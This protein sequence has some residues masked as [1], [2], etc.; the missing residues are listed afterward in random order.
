MNTMTKKAIS[1]P[2]THTPT[3]MQK[4]FTKYGD[5]TEAREALS[6]VSDSYEELLES[7]KLLMDCIK[8]NCFGDL[9]L[10]KAQQAIANAEEKY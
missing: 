3:I 9:E 6:M 10:N 7:C 8:Q 2:Q 4:A 1:K 5:Y